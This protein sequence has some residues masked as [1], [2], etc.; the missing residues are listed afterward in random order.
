MDKV[1]EKMLLLID[2]LK[3][4]NIIRFD[5]EFCNALDL[6]KQTLTKIK[7]SE[8]YF[9]VAHIRMARK[10][11]R[12]NLEWIFG[13]SDAIFID[14]PVDPRLANKEYVQRLEAVNKIVNPTITKTQS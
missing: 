14:H 5:Q 1:N 10:V 6:P 2:I 12:V 11:Y 4:L 7:N 3:S 8:K 9:T 13:F